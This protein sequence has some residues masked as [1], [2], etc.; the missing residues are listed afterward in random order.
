MYRRLLMV[1]LAGIL[2]SGALTA[3]VALGESPRPL[4]SKLWPVPKAP[5]LAQHQPPL[6]GPRPYYG[7]AMGATYYN[8]GFFGAHQHSQLSTHTGYEDQYRQHGRVRG[9]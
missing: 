3:N 5:P 4:F 2:L 7:Q 1:L 9:Y 8:W 6:A